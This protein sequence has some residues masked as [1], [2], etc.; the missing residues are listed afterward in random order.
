MRRRARATPP[1]FTAAGRGDRQR[2]SWQERGRRGALAR[3][4]RGQ[5]PGARGGDRLRTARDLAGRGARRPPAPTGVARAGHGHRRTRR[6][7]RRL[8]PRD[9]PAPHAEPPPAREHEL[10]GPRRRRAWPA[11]VSRAAEAPYLAQRA[12]A[13]T[14]SLRPDRRRRPGVRTLAAAARRA[15]HARRACAARSGRGH[16][17]RRRRHPGRSGDDA[18]L[19]RQ[20]AGGARGAGDDRA[21]SRA[22]RSTRA[23]GW[24]G[25]RERRP[26]SPLLARR[27]RAHRPPRGGRRAASRATPPATPPPGTPMDRGGAL[28]ARAAGRGRGADTSTA[29]CA[30]RGSRTA[31]VSLRRAGGG[32]WHRHPRPHARARRP[33]RMTLLELLDTRRLVLCVGSGGVGKTTTAAALAVA[34]AR[35]GRRTVVLTVDPAQRL[36]DALAI[37]ELEGHPRRVPLRGGERLDAMLLDVKRTF[38]ELIEGLASSPEQARRVLDNRLYQNLSGTLAGSAEYM[39]VESVLRLSETGEYDLLV[40]D[41]P[42]ARH[43]V[44]FLAAPRRLLALLDSRAFSILKDPTSILPGA[45]SR[46][47]QIV[48]TGVLRGLERFT[49]IGLVREIGDFVRAIEDLTGALRARVAQVNALLTSEATALVLVTAPEPRLVTE[50]E[51]LARA[52]TAVRLRA[53]GVV[54]NRVLPRARVGG[55]AATSPRAGA[56]AA[57]ARRLAR[58]FAEV[59]TLAARQEATLEPLLRSAGAPV[60][61]EVPLLANPPGSLADLDV[62]VG[63]LLPHTDTA[64]ASA[65]GRGA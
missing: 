26:P 34:A 39:A 4:R 49:G 29:A 40:V 60:L 48:L 47:A 17:A 38:D 31:A 12:S 3:G 18:R 10:P 20:H 35:R 23:P 58:A 11:R 46:I 5:A 33:R 37:D 64:A 16:A 62:L 65:R 41:T 27:R 50:T 30:R 25:D 13:W 52:L 2:R 7:P 59:R 19:H 43:A 45:G 57:L 28:H 32:G 36:R 9:P 15:P 42:P 53:H 44:D 6:S 24:T 8:R 55:G 51:D 54:V 1:L 63:H 61:A 21:S 56:S 22:R 14:A